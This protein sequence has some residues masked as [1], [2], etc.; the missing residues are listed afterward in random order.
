MEY[1]VLS[2]HHP[3]SS[4]FIEGAPGDTYQFERRKTTYPGWIWC[5]DG[6]G[7]QAWVPEAYLM[8]TGEICQLTRDYDSRELDLDSDEVVRVL[9]EEC[10]WAWVVN[11]KEQMGW[12][13]LECLIQ[14]EKDNS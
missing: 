12:V 13:P 1:K 5:F 4:D 10:G 8:I 3:A 9:E 14:L 11:D 6:H 2:P 7:N